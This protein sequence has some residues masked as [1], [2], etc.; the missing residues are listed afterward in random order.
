MAASAVPAG[1]AAL[2]SEKLNAFAGKAVGDISAAVSAALVII[3]DRLGLYR[4]L[5]G[6]G[7]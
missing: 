5:A 6:S 2:D 7:R 1:P 4:A 3:G